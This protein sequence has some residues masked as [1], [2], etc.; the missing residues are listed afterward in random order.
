[1]VRIYSITRFSMLLL[2]ISFLHQRT[3][4]QTVICLKPGIS[5]FET[6]Y[7]QA[8]KFIGSLTSDMENT[9]IFITLKKSA[10]GD[11]LYFHSNYKPL[12]EQYKYPVK[13]ASN[14]SL[15]LNYITDHIVNIDER[16]FS[17]EFEQAFKNHI[18]FYIN[19]KVFYHP[20]FKNLDF[21]EAL[22]INI[23]NVNG[24]VYP[25]GFRLYKTQKELKRMG[26]YSGV[27]DGVNGGN[28][29]KAFRSLNDELSLGEVGDFF[30]TNNNGKR[31]LTFEDPNDFIKTYSS[32]KNRCENPLSICVNSDLVVTFSLECQGSSIEIS[33]EGELT[34]TAA[35]G[36]RSRSMILSV[37]EF[38]PENSAQTSNIEEYTNQLNAFYRGE[39]DVLNYSFNDPIDFLNSYQFSLQRDKE[40]CGNTTTL[41]LGN[42][43]GISFEINCLGNFVSVTSSGTLTLSTKNNPTHTIEF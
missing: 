40:E 34:I 36:N 39:E 13:I 15:D 10:Q 38:D 1:M 3:F 17:H 18:Q 16:Y 27:P 11:F 43:T 20:T 28:T 31:R 12:G 6:E 4:A 8:Q 42:D 14:E 24:R 30:I 22:N 37:E 23:V 25:N 26:H 29:Q 19:Y 33:T 2:F 9:K 32:V 35:Q 5:G 41:C 7:A 21:G